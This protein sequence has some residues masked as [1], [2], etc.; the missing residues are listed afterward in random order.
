MKASALAGMAIMS[1]TF[2]VTA[3]GADRSLKE[4]SL[5]NHD[6]F[7]DKTLQEQNERLEM[8]S[9]IGGAMG[10]SENERVPQKQQENPNEKTALT[11]KEAL[12]RCVEN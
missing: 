6:V 11:C 10:G 1:L 9:V 5:E 12:E 2:S 8:N 7:E 3:I 4:R